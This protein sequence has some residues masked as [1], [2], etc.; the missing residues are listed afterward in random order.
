MTPNM[1]LMAHARYVNEE[2]CLMKDT[3]L[4]ALDALDY[5]VSCIEN[6]SNRTKALDLYAAVKAKF[7]NRKHTDNL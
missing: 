4:D 3:V 5:A 2:Y 7:G 6:D 1:P